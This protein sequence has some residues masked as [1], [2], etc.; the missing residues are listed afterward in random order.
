MTIDYDKLKIAHELADK[1]HKKTAYQ[2]CITT[3]I[4]CSKEPG[5]VF[6]VLET[7]TDNDENNIEESYYCIDELI[8]KLT[9]LTDSPIKIPNLKYQIGQEVFYLDP[10]EGIK[11]MKI[12]GIR[13]SKDDPENED[14][15]IYNHLRSEY[16]YS[17]K[18]S[19]IEAQIEY[20][21]SLKDHSEDKL[22]K[23]CPYDPDGCPKCT[24]ECQHESDKR[25]HKL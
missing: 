15:H 23:V 2:I 24:D 11:C 18:E 10:F 25:E 6:Y 22:E 9:K 12:D 8:A 14:G 21:Q 3:G 7:Y 19:L 4:R 5:F 17:S 20:W 16:L 1:W 13:F